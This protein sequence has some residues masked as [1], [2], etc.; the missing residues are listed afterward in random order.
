MQLNGDHASREAFAHRDIELSQ[1]EADHV[2]PIMAAYDGIL[3]GVR[4]DLKESEPPDE[5]AVYGT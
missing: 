5:E 1:D 2:L 3:S 4:R